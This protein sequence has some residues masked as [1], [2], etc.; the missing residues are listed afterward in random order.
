MARPLTG[1]PGR[2]LRFVEVPQEV[3]QHVEVTREVPV[4]VIKEVERLKEVVREVPIEVIREKVGSA[5]RR[6]AG[7]IANG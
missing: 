7:Q 4:D 1:G 6:V 2:G 5:Q 3:I